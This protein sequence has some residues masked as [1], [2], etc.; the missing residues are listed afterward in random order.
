MDTK[1]LLELAIET[2][3][4][5][6]HKIEDEIQA[7]TKG[8]KAT[9]AVLQSKQPQPIIVKKRRKRSAA[10]RKAQADKMRAYWAKRKAEG[11]KKTR[12]PRK[13]TKAKAA[14]A[15]LPVPF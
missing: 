7:L 5:Q 9:L 1:R 14:K 3:R 2:L 4:A 8:A 11:A 6:Q 10:A 12:K 15:A 13:T